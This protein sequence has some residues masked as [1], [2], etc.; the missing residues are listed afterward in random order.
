MPFFFL[1][2]RRNLM[3]SPFEGPLTKRY[4]VQEEVVFLVQTREMTGW[5]EGIIVLFFFIPDYKFHSHSLLCKSI[6]DVADQP[7]P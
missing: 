7:T 1:L 2:L 6:P 3:P 5:E 4:I